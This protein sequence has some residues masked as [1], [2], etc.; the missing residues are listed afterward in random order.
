MSDHLFLVKKIKYC[1]ALSKIRCSSHQLNIEKGRHAK[2]KIPINE[3][4]CASCGVVEDEFH[5]VI[6]CEIFQTQRS[7][8]FNK[9]SII[10]AT[11]A[12]MN[13]RAK[14][15]YLFSSKESKML[16]NLGKFVYECLLIRI[17]I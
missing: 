15:V 16:S 5:F 3:R 7:N 1:H 10:D 12:F 11:F 17:N 4:L 8:L 13:D 14:F 6:E 9:I 2:P